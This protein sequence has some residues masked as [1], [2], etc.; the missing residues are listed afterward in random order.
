MS[1]LWGVE[2]VILK[3]NWEGEFLYCQRRLN[4]HILYPV[5]IL[6]LNLYYLVLNCH[7]YFILKV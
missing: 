3:K 5:L 6:M 4:A 2:I 1:Q 7:H